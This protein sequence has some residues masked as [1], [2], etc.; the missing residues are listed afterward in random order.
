M[1]VA[2]HVSRSAVVTGIGRTGDMNVPSFAG[3]PGGQTIPV[4][5][6]W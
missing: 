2:A 6:L 3:R 1:S 5:A 4:C